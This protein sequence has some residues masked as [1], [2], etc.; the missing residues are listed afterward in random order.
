VDEDFTIEFVDITFSAPD[1][2][3]W[4]DLEVVLTSP[5]GTRSVLAE[6]HQS[7]STAYRYDK[8]RFGSTRHLGEGARG[9]WTLTVRD[10][11]A[12]D[13]GTF[14]EWKLEIHGNDR[15]RAFP[16]AIGAGTDT[17]IL[18]ALMLLLEE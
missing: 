1:H 2:P 14:S 8:W 6:K 3:Y 16:A 11:G 17:T 10:L 4:G 15:N 5:A 13:T 9:T 12:L 7:D 18:P